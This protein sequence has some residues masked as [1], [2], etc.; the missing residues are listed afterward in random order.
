MAIKTTGRRGAG[1]SL[2]VRKLFPLWSA[3]RST[4]ALGAIRNP[5]PL[6]E[7]ASFYYRF[8]SLGPPSNAS[9]LANATQSGSR[10]TRTPNKMAPFAHRACRPSNG[11]CQR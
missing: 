5:Q 8:G 3:R 4:T 11:N 7:C 6:M 10:A 1:A 2:N 9:R